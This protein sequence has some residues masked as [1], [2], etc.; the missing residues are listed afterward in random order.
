[1]IRR[2]TLPILKRRGADVCGRTI[3]TTPSVC[4]A[5][6]G[7][8]KLGEVNG[9]RRIEDWPLFVLFLVLGSL[10]GL[11]S[12]LIAKAVVVGRRRGYNRGGLAKRIP[13]E[14]RR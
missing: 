12:G 10:T 11:L 14:T 4:H 9:E 2:T 3:P 7:R 5:E 8:V 13:Q 6:G 1:M